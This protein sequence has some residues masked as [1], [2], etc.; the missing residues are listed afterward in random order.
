MQD[1]RGSLNS[2]GLTV[3]CRYFLRWSLSA[4]L[5]IPEFNWLHCPQAAECSL[6]ATPVL[7]RAVFLGSQDCVSVRCYDLVWVNFC[8]ISLGHNKVMS[9]YSAVLLCYNLSHPLFYICGSTHI[10]SV[11]VY[12]FPIAWVQKVFPPGILREDASAPLFLLLWTYRMGCNSCHFSS[13]EKWL[14]I[15]HIFQNVSP[16][17]CHIFH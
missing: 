6:S 7:C 11:C 5:V 12:L 9:M 3:L 17:T 15:K 8:K 13:S 2:M 1:G 4:S 16:V 14:S 10:L